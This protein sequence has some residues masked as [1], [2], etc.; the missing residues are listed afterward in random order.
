VFL[1][2][3]ISGS[4]HLLTSSTSLQPIHDFS[5]SL[6]PHRHLITQ[7]MKIFIAAAA[8]LIVATN[9]LVIQ[10]G[11][12]T[13][14]LTSFGGAPGKVS[15]LADGQNHLS[16]SG[17]PVATYII[18]ADG[19]IFD[20]NG[21]GCMLMPQT[22]RLQCD[23][24]ASPTTGFSIGCDGTLSYNG[25]P[26]FVACQTTDNSW[27]I[28]LTAPRTQT[29]CVDISLNADACQSGCPPTPS[30]PSTS[31]SPSPT[32][33]AA[34]SPL[35]P[36][37]APK[38]CPADLS[39]T[40]E[41]PHLIVP[42]SSTNPDNAYGT[43]Y[44]GLVS[45]SDIRSIFNFEIKPSDTGKTCSLVFLF[46]RQDQLTTSSFMISGDANVGFTSLSAA[47]DPNTTY[48]NAPGVAKDFGFFNLSPGNSYTIATF[49]C[50]A[51]TRQGYSMTGPNTD[52]IYFQDSRPSPQ[53]YPLI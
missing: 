5:S 10:D 13:F 16:A 21:R 12:C 1:K 30:D 40:F 29:S 9:A 31:P 35:T 4:L 14:K 51:G 2:R 19:G 11:G 39:G 22:T 42:V 52:F 15:Q 34:T 24:G 37:P 26:R 43:S 27:N 20:Q 47:A 41:F 38:T 17:L 32:T 33:P 18:G 25:S 44:N 7:I 3:L 6:L 50:P 8:T 23:S 46:P 28:S 53:V 36:P 49:D 45:R 48:N